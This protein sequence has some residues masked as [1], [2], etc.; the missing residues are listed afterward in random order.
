MAYVSS[1]L[2]KS[3]QVTVR[4]TEEF[5]ASP[6][7]GSAD[8]RKAPCGRF[9]R[10]LRAVFF[11]SAVTIGTG[12]SSAVQERKPPGYIKTGCILKQAFQNKMF[13][14]CNNSL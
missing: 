1:K 14:C 4:G 10:L 3:E 2:V 6:G 9:F 11:P 8:K 13:L 12:I 7:V 5:K